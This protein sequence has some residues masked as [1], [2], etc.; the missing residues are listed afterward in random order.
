VSKAFNKAMTRPGRLPGD[1]QTVAA[2]KRVILEGS[3]E[4][5][6]GAVICLF[7]EL[8]GTEALQEEVVH[9]RLPVWPAYLYFRAF[10]ATWDDQIAQDRELLLEQTFATSHPVW[11]TVAACQLLDS[12]DPVTDEARVRELTEWVTTVGDR[13][14]A[15][16]CIFYK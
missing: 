8:A 4:L 7:D 16:E 6:S 3:L 11:A 15:I 2:C 14:V 1:A 13:G 5:A 12:L 10:R 9:E